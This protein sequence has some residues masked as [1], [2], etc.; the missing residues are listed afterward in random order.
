MVEITP[1]AL[2]NIGYKTYI[3]FAALNLVAAFLVFRF[4]PETAYL[5]L[6]SIDLLFLT[7]NNDLGNNAP[8]IKRSLW[9]KILPSETVARAEVMVKEAKAENKRR[10]AAET[11]DIETTN[12]ATNNNE[13]NDISKTTLNMQHLEYQ[14]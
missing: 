3:I 4:Y 11:D 5:R 14:R 9:Q 8:K 7:N 1:I 13:S 12:T 2:K 10:G 6:E